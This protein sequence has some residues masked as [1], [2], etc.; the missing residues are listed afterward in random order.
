MRVKVVKNKVAPPFKEAEFDIIFGKGI[1]KTA[2][3]LELAIKSN[4]MIKSGSWISYNNENIGQGKEKAKE[5]LESHP[6]VLKEVEEKVRE[7]YRV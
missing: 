1:S 3:I 6:E 5:Y 4:V 7:I 2:D